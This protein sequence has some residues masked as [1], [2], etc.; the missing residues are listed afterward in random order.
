MADVHEEE[1]FDSEEPK[2]SIEGS[3]KVS[4]TSDA[5]FTAKG[6][7]L[8]I[9]DTLILDGANV[10]LLRGHRYG[11][12]GVNGGSRPVFRLTSVLLMP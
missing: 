8:A 2:L 5:I 11:L 9:E 7:S 3:I 1:L 10:V 4:A 12:V 6:L